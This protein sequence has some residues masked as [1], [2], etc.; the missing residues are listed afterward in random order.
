MA[1]GKSVGLRP[2]RGNIT[3]PPPA[4]HPLRD[5]GRRLDGQGRSVVTNNDGGLMPNTL[6]LSRLHCPHWL[7]RVHLLTGW[8]LFA[9][10]SLGACGGGSGSRVV[11]APPPPPSCVSTA[12][13]VCTQSGQLQGTIEARLPRFSRH[14]FRRAAG[15]RLALAS[16]S[17]SG[18]LA[19]RAQRD[20]V[21]KPLPADRHQRRADGGRRL[22]HPERLRGQSPCEFETTGDGVLSRRRGA[23]G[24]RPGSAVERRPAAVRATAS[25]W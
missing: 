2:R 10:L 23:H 14:S 16:T 13:V 9:A 4:A 19:G 24:Q 25:L 5:I 1:T 17:G 6:G 12:T 7:Y 8:A 22:P 18:K 3:E 20:G 21:R 15:G 11:G